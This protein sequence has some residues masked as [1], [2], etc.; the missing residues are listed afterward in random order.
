MR[1][2]SSRLLGPVVDVLLCL[3]A[4]DAGLL[5]DAGRLGWVPMAVEPA[6]YLH[7]PGPT[8]IVALHVVGALVLLAHRRARY[9]VAVVLA[10]L[11]VVVPLFSALFATYAV[12]RCGG[13][14]TTVVALAERA[15]RAERESD[16]R[17]EAAL[18]RERAELAVSH[19]LCR[20]VLDMTLGG[21]RS[22]EPL[23][24]DPASQPAHASGLARRQ[25][26]ATGDEVVLAPEGAVR[27]VPLPARDA[28]PQC[29]LPATRRW[30]SRC[31]ASSPSWRPSCRRDPLSRP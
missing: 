17:A 9:V 18:L 26:F 23:F 31:R 5:R 19:G 2:R 29:R 25:Q 1:T 28:P 14:L 7:S 3:L 27:A 24:A 20:G 11:S 21:D 4:V 16:A 22:V 6:G 30:C 8:V 15:E 10:A 13:R 12:A